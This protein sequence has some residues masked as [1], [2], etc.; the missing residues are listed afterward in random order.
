MCIIFLGLGKSNSSKYKVVVAAN[1]DEFYAR[2]A[3]KAQFLSDNANILC[4]TDA[5]PGVEGGTWLGVNRNGKIA[6][7]TNILQPSVEKDGSPRGV[8]VRKF[9]ENHLS[10]SNY[11]KQDLM[12]GNF[13][14]FNFVGIQ[15][16]P[17][18]IECDYYGNKNKDSPL[19]IKEGL[20]VIACTD[21]NT[22]WNKVTHGE[23]IF[24]H[25]LSDSFSDKPDVLAEAL[26]SKLLSNSECLYPD[27]LV[28]AQ[29]ASRLPD[30]FLEK[31]CSIMI[32]GIPTYGT[33]TQTVV[34]V[35]LDNH[36]TFYE[37]N[38]TDTTDSWSQ[39]KYEFDINLGN[40]S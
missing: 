38:R 14:S 21:K 13:R 32:D 22:P 10:P 27:D 35:D 33:R 34:L 30:D 11:I 7:L 6:F 37:R 26:F 5:Q 25:L 40:S 18:G 19:S 31:Y 15:L 16:K 1:R 39:E 17:D 8:I 4:G 20:H 9:L 12:E 24:T 3:N 36:V 23:G 28:K 29:S 2:P